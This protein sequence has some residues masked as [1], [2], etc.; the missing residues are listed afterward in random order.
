MA[1][2]QVARLPGAISFVPAAQVGRS[3]KVL[4]ID[5]A[6]RASRDIDCGRSKVKSPVAVYFIPSRVSSR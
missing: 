3:V 4:K 6:H 1:L 5:G 2:D